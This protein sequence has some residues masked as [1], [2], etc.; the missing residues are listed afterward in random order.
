MKLK[1]LFSSLTNTR[2]SLSLGQLEFVSKQYGKSTQKKYRSL[3]FRI[4]M[5]SRKKQEKV[6]LL[7]FGLTE[8]K[9][10]RFNKRKK[11]TEEVLPIN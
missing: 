8:T 5:I 7:E 4:I 11:S 6:Y 10:I 1:I 3:V 9:K 2:I